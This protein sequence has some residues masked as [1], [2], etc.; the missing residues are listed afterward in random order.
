VKPKG[1]NEFLEESLEVKILDPSTNYKMEYKLV[2]DI[3]NNIES[4]LTG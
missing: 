4:K 1:K 2:S 3:L